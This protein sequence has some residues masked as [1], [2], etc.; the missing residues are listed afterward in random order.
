VAAAREG[1]ARFLDMIPVGS[2]AS[3]GFNNR[4]EF[5]NV[6]LGTP[7]AVVSIVPDSIK[8]GIRE[9]QNIF[10]P[11]NEWRVPITVNG[12]MRA[13]LTVAKVGGTWK[14]V[15]FGA[16]GLASELGKFMKDRAMD[17]AGRR[18]ELLRLYQLHS[19]FLLLTDTTQAAAK[20]N[21]C[22]LTSATMMLE[23]NGQAVKSVYSKATLLPLIRE[24]FGREAQNEQ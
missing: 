19:D 17:I 14:A 22:P 8:N 2:E 12:E 16:S 11:V 18:V 15:D 23:R 7:I 24:D 20:E 6:G 13:L 4:G 5:G 21:I 1:V 3:Y 10:V 9:D